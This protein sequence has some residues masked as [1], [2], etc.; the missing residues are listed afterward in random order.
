MLFIPDNV[1][2]EPECK[3]TRWSI[4]KT[5]KNTFQPDPTY[6]LVGNAVGIGRVSS[7]IRNFS[8]EVSTTDVKRTFITRSGRLYQV[9]G[10]QDGLSKDALYVLGRWLQVNGLNIETIKYLSFDS[11]INE[12]DSATNKR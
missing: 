5:P 1:T 10:E 12:W 6:H 3:L 7:P 11:F 8:R 4:F 2:I 9:Y